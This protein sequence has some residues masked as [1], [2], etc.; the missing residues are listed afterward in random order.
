[1]GIRILLGSVIVALAC[2]GSGCA[3]IITGPYQEIDVITSPPCKITV[4]NFTGQTPCTLSLER[5]YRHD[6]LLER[7]GYSSKRIH[8]VPDDIN[9]YCFLSIFTPYFIG[10]IVD[11]T[12]GACF[13]LSPDYIDTY[14]QKEPEQKAAQPPPVTGK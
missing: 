9:A 12:T 4:N 13:R 5:A 1:M 3:Y 10:V 2:S 14:L 7:D 11:V 8:I 6:I